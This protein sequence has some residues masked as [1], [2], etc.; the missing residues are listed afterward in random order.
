MEDIKTIGF[1]I[2][3]VIVAYAIISIVCWIIRR[4]KK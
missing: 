1:W 4:L 3:C 2:L